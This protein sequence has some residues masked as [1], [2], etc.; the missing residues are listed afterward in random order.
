MKKQAVS[1]EMA[2]FDGG[3]TVST[4]IRVDNRGYHKEVIMRMTADEWKTQQ[5]VPARYVSSD[6]DDN[7][8][9]FKA[10]FEA[11]GKG[12]VEFAI[13]YQV[14]GDSFWDNNEGDNYTITFN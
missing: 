10:E 3:K 1:L 12:N 14:N 8:D 4:L 2:M 5:D 9:K 7:S 13:L 6:L 11:N